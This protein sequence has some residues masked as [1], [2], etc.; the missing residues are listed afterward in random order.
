MSVQLYYI[1][2]GINQYLLP[3][4][5]S[6]WYHGRPTFTPDQEMAGTFTEEQADALLALPTMHPHSRKEAVGS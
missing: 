6:N 4:E 2:N 1:R 3:N 5:G